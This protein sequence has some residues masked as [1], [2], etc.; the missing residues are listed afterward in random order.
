VSKEAEYRGYAERA[1]AIAGQLKDSERAKLLK[2]AEEWDTLAS[3]YERRSKWTTSWIRLP[4]PTSRLRLRPLHL[5][6][7]IFVALT[8]G[9]VAG[10]GWTKR[11]RASRPQGRNAPPT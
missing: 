1:R 10:A 4:K 9:L 11:R 8:S 7:T 5:V 2:I 6:V 3:D